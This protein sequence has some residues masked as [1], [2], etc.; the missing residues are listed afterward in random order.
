MLVSFFAYRKYLVDC[1]LDV[2]VL[3]ILGL[4]YVLKKIYCRDDL[5]YNTTVM[6]NL[7]SEMPEGTS[8]TLRATWG[9]VRGNG[10]KRVENC[11]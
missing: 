9:N 1:S 11:H 6:P 10:E 7:M 3:C 8:E 4:K 2:I 5:T